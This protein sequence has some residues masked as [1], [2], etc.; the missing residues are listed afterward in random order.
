LDPGRPLSYLFWFREQGQLDA[1]LTP[2][3]LPDF[4]LSVLCASAPGVE[5][6]NAGAYGALN[7]E[8]LGWHEGVLEDLG[9][10]NLRWPALREPGEVVGHVDVQGRQVPCYTPVGDYQCALVGALLGAEEVSLNIATGSQVSL[11]MTGLTLG[12][13]QTRP[14]FEGKFLNT[15]TYPPGGRALNVIVDLL[16]HLAR[17]QGLDLKCPW[18]AIARAAEEVTDTDL[19]VDLNFFPTPRGDR[20]RIANIRGDNLTLGHLFRA[21]FKNMADIFYDCA[22]RLSP[23][24]SWRS[25]VFSG[26]L[27]CKLEVLRR[28]IQQRFAARCRITPRE[29]DTLYGLLILASVFSGRARSV[30]ELTRELRAA[31][32]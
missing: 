23:E 16:C 32:L 12:D 27:A 2:V 29:E 26:G 24:K 22:V 8:T 30:E 7:L 4:V 5:I 10:D 6:T 21:A 14:F 13:Y 15:F 3:S 31:L 11:M 18:E 20:G 9:L 17:S 28:V 19:E 1:G 25:L